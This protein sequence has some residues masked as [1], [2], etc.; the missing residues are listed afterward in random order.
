MLKE[1]EAEETI[2]FFVA[3]LSLVAFRLGGQAPC[4][5][6]YAYAVP[7]INAA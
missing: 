6:G 7:T 5:P 2:D 4:P 3:F 1:T